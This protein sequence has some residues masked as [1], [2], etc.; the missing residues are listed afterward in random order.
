MASTSPSFLTALF[1]LTVFVALVAFDGGVRFGRWRSRQPDP[2]PLLPVRT[3]MASILHLLAFIVG[4]V[5][6]QSS[7]HF[8]AR[9]RSIFELVDQTSEV[10]GTGLSLLDKP[11]RCPHT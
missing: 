9:A 1:I 10:A 2:E 3:L 11:Y 4:F 6:G 7:S 8:D 5:F